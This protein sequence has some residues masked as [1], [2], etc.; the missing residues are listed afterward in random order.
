[1]FETHLYE[2]DTYFVDK[3]NIISGLR[4]VCKTEAYIWKFVKLFKNNVNNIGIVN[5]LTATICFESIC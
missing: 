4:E 5:T 3:P 1:M 2:F